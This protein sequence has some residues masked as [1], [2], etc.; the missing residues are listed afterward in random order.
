[1]KALLLSLI[2]LLPIFSYSEPTPWETKFN[3]YIKGLPAEVAALLKRTDD[4][5]RWGGEEPY[6]KERAKQIAE[7]MKKSKCDLVEKDTKN[8]LVKYKDK[9]QIIDKIKK[10]S[11]L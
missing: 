4:C 7:A 5:N 6:D 3:N 10:F 2:F 9:P 11:E 8:F 1:M